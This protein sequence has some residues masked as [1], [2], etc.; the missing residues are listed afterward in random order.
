MPRKNQRAQPK[1]GGSPSSH[2]SHSSHSS[3]SSPSSHSTSLSRQNHNDIDGTKFKKKLER[4]FNQIPFIDT[5]N[6]DQF[7]TEATHVL[8]SKLP[9]WTQYTKDEDNYNRN[10]NFAVMVTKLAKPEI[11]R[12][13]TTLLK[14][15]VVYTN[16]DLVSQLEHAC[17]W[18]NTQL[19]GQQYVGI[20]QYN[21]SFS[22]RKLKSV[23]WMLHH[24]LK[25]LS[26]KPYC[27]C[28]ESNTKSEGNN[29]KFLLI[30]DGTYSGGQIISQ[31]TN[32]CTNTQRSTIYVVAMFITQT[33]LDRFAGAFGP[34]VSSKE[35]CRVYRIGTNTL[36]VWNG[37]IM[38]PSV[39]LELSRIVRTMSKPQQPI[40]F[41][42]HQ[43]HKCV[44]YCGSIV[45]FEHKL[46]DHLSLPKIVTNIFLKEMPE[47][48][49]KMPPYQ[50]SE[51][52]NFI[53]NKTKDFTF[54]CIRQ[55][56]QQRVGYFNTFMSLFSR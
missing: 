43:L 28:N 49:E 46:P 18:L 31:V 37:S 17:S 8:K 35:K 20:L 26:T 42:V 44:D 50:P 34:P 6:S 38:M 45:V 19:S 51:I 24:A 25:Y 56:Q 2:S 23:D 33:A 12:I 13:F 9:H 22:S 40:E 41:V 48:Y 52:K 32:I 4:V 29:Q 53:P 21:I 10:A 7:L 15:V 16:K 14:S 27:L 11:T 47:H 5:S 3:P 30:D 36:C 1:K 55:Q 54:D 39:E